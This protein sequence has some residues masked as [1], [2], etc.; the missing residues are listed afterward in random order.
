[1]PSSTLFSLLCKSLA[2]IPRRSRSKLPRRSHKQIF[3]PRNRELQWGISTIKATE[4]MLQAK[5]NIILSLFWIRMGTEFYRVSTS[6]ASVQVLKI[7]YLFSQWPEWLPVLPVVETC[8]LNDCNWA[9]RQTDSR[10]TGRLGSWATGQP[11]SQAVRQ[12]GVPVL[13]LVHL[14]IRL[15]QCQTRIMIGLATCWA[16]RPRG[17]SSLSSL[18]WQLGSRV[19]NQE[20]RIKSQ[21][22]W[23]SKIENQESQFNTGRTLSVSTLCWNVSFRFYLCWESS[24][25]FQSLIHPFPIPHSPGPLPFPFPIEK[26]LLGTCCDCDP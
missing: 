23:E 10:E 7:S 18:K 6:W 5:E 26:C 25:L 9:A 12:F 13:L 19:K 15:L 3:M 14:F 20:S 11:A 21:E 16:Q 24:L 17:S 8:R 2:A 22:N 1:M 4:L